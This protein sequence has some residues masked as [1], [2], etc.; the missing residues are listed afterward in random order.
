MAPPSGVARVRPG[1]PIQRMEGR[2]RSKIDVTPSV[3]EPLFNLWRGDISSVRGT[4]RGSLVV[5]TNAKWKPPTLRGGPDKQVPPKDRRGTL[6]VPGEREWM[7]QPRIAN[8][9]SRSLRI[10]AGE[11]GRDDHVPA[12]KR[13]G[14]LIVPDETYPASGRFSAAGERWRYSN[15]LRLTPLSLLGVTS[16]GSVGLCQRPEKPLKHCRRAG[17]SLSHKL[18]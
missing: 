11:Y 7:I 18:I 2:L 1:P 13:S 14:T 12:R 8:L 6:V 4:R 15:Q 16:P 5:P 9:T 3:T 10:W 17:G